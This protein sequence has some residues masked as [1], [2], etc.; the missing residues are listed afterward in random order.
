MHLYISV[1][2]GVCVQGMWKAQVY[3]QVTEM[4]GFKV[5]SHCDT[6]SFISVYD[7]TLAQPLLQ[8]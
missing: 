4:H 5:N 1:I 7:I 2:S 3:G 8:P 6:A